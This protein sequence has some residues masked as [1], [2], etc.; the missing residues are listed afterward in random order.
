M[1]NSTTYAFL[2]KWK[3]ECEVAIFSNTINFSC[4]PKYKVCI[5][6]LNNIKEIWVLEK[7][8]MDTL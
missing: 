3:S 8:N 2:L 1:N 5:K 6:Q 4:G 7:N